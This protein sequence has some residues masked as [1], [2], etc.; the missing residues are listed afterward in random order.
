MSFLLAPFLC[1]LSVHYGRAPALFVFPCFELLP[2]VVPFFGFP[3]R[4]RFEK[5]PGMVPLDNSE[6]VLLWSWYL[7]TQSTEHGLSAFG[8]P[9]CFPFGGALVK[10]EFGSLRKMSNVISRDRGKLGIVCEH[11]FPLFLRYLSSG[12]VL[13]CLKEKK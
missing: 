3:G 4:L 10:P 1:L 8:F 7:F 5:Y 12:R 13:N 6:S 2:W 11:F 9:L